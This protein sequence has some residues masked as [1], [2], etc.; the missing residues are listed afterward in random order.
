MASKGK[1][2]FVTVEVLKEM[3]EIQ[4]CAYRSIIQILINDMKLE[5]KSVKKYAEEF[6]LSTQFMSSIKVEQIEDRVKLP[7]SYLSNSSMDD[8]YHY[9]FQLT[10][11]AQLLKLHRPSR[12]L[13]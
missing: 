6:K 11:K 12:L 8:E 2:E 1:A 7:E 3:M 10:V 5:I 13:I 4:D 9:Q